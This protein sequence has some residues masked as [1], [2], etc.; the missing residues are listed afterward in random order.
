M[1]VTDLT[2][3]SKVLRQMTLVPG[4]NMSGRDL[5][6]IDMSG[7]DL[8]RVNFNRANLASADHNDVHRL[9]NSR[10]FS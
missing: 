7:L 8:S 1:T 2:T 9:L 4:A 5:S 10:R 6:G 3:K